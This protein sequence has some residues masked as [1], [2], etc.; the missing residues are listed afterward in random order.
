MDKKGVSAEIMAEIDRK[1]QEEYGIPQI[2]LME[3]AGRAAAEVILDELGTLRDERIAI[4]CGKGNNG[5]DGFVVGRYLANECPAHLSIY[6]QEAERIRKG[7]PYD[8][9]EI[10]RGMGVEIRPLKDFFEETATVADFTVAID[11]VFGTGFKGELTEEYAALGRSLNSAGLRIY[12]IDVPSGLNATTGEAAKD[13][14][15]A[16]KTITFGLPKQ[17]FFIKDGPDVCGEVIVRNIGF[18]EALLE[19]YL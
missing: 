3:N 7:A 14:I 9:F 19:Q 18:P 2:V 8:N 10:A 12:S 1:A 5:G 11:S 16:Y 6:V 4:F 15:R 13:C 17:G